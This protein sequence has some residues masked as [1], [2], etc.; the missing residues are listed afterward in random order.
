MAIAIITFFLGCG[1][2][3]GIYHLIL[4][5][6][7]DLSKI[8]GAA[9]VTGFLIPLK[10][11]RKWFDFIKYEVIIFNILG[12]AP[13]LTAL[14]LVLNYTIT[15][16]ETTVDHKIELVYTQGSGNSLEH[17]I[18]LENNAHADEPKI[19]TI[20][21]VEFIGFSDKIFYRITL[22]DGL[23]GLKVIKNREFVKID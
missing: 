1:T 12:L 2:I 18:I 15:S 17:L 7:Y 14:F 13:F 23:F 5:D 21:D 9:A 10:F 8:I 3:L 19:I 11:Y 6:F 20:D 16:N 4:I 22:A